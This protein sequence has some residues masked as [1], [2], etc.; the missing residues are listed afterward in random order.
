MLMR[1]CKNTYACM[2]M[3]RSASIHMRMSMYMLYMSYMHMLLYMW[4]MYRGKRLEHIA[5]E[6]D[7]KRGEQSA[8]HLPRGPVK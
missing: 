3:L 6:L 4:C 7:D 8:G 5:C 1:V 2:Q